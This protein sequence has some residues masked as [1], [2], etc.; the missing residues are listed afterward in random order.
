MGESA[1][2]VKTCS[3]VQD[4]KACA[5]EAA[6]SHRWC[7]SCKSRYQREYTALRITMAYSEGAVAMRTAI[8]LQFANLGV[9]P[10]AGIDVARHVRKM[11]I[12]ERA[13]S[14]APEE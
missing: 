3:R 5:N 11:E 14:D 8:M 1:V 7:K 4:G 9:M 12:P 2:E 10:I 13:V 6:G